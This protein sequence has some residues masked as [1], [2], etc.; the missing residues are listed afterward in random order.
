LLHKHPFDTAMDGY[1]G[2]NTLYRLLRP[3]VLAELV[4][5]QTNYVDFSVDRAAVVLLR[6]QA[7]SYEALTGAGSVL[8]EMRLDWAKETQHVFKGRL[9]HAANLM[10][11]DADPPR[12]ARF[13][14][15]AAIL[16]Q[17]R[18]D[19]PTGGMARFAHLVDGMSP[20]REPVFWSRLVAYGH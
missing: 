11:V 2:P 18:Q 12:C 5:R 9:Q 13:D 7:A 4:E 8:C 10:I 1:F 16:Q 15:F 3:L 20:G 17:A 6:F 19:D 14:E